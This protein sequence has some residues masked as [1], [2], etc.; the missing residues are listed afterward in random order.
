MTD[1][2]RYVYAVC[3]PLDAP[4]HADLTG[5]GGA[6]PRQ[7]A[8]DGL[9]AVVGPVPER[10]FG[11]EQLHARLEDLD[12]LAATARAHQSVVAALATVTCPLPLRLGTVF[13][14]DSGVRAMLQ[15]E[16][17][18]LRRILDRIDGQVEW[19][20]KVWL[21]AESVAEAAAPQPSGAPE[22]GRDYL[23]RRRAGNAAREQSAAR[24]EAFARQLH[25]DLSRYAADARLHPPQSGPLTDAG[26]GRNVLN[27]AYLVPRA[28]SEE[29]LELVGRAE[30]TL[31][32]LQV[33]VTGP[34]AAYSFTDDPEAS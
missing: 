34:W 5:V 18:R 19:G 31:P 26:S 9:V 30:G 8:H 21:G 4:L 20:V 1:D 32:G 6:P 7:L 13:R 2:L 12:W 17:D 22:S 28:R 25:E 23:R 15:D 16:S 3:R 29:F 24:A 33:E 14:D 27:S 10:D 11:R